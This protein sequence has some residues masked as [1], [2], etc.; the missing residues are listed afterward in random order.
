MKFGKKLQL[1][2]TTFPS[3]VRDK[4]STVKTPP[5]YVTAVITVQNN[6]QTSSTLYPSLISF[7][8]CTHPPPLPPLEMKKET[9]RL[10]GADQLSMAWVQEGPRIILKQATMA[11]IDTICKTLPN[12][13]NS[14][15]FVDVLCSHTRYAKLSGSDNRSIL[16]R[17]LA[18]DVTELS[19]NN[20]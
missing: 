10:H 9:V 13:N 15:K 17:V 8:Y 7:S 20:L 14:N 19:L 11:D 6:A 3:N 12:P 5:P 16:L 1:Y 18:D 2:G 4:M